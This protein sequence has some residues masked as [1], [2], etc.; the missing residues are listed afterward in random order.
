MLWPVVNVIFIILF[1]ARLLIISVILFKLARK[2]RFLLVFFLFCF[3]D[4]QAIICA[5]FEAYL[6]FLFLNQ[7]FRLFREAF[8]FSFVSNCSKANLPFCEAFLLSHF[9]TAQKADLYFAKR[10]PFT[11]FS[12]CSEAHSTLREAF[13]SFPFIIH[14]TNLNTLAAINSFGFFM[15]RN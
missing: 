8:S 7:T 9:P 1:R 13:Y 10:F 12:N 15:Q 2:H 14:F 11:D 3:N 5:V 4:S 6:V